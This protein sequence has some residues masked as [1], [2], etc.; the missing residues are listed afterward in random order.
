MLLELASRRLLPNNGGNM[1]DIKPLSYLDPRL[2]APAVDVSPVAEGNLAATKSV[3]SGINSAISSGSGALLKMKDDEVAAA[4]YSDQRGD[5]LFD[6]GMKEKELGQRWDIANLNA[7]AYS[8]SADRD[9]N[10]AK[11]KYMIENGI[12]PSTAGNPLNRLDRIKLS[13]NPN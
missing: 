2:F 6:R 13:L 4:K 10:Q 7:N 11:L 8:R 3:M 12:D 5:I 9:L 1:I